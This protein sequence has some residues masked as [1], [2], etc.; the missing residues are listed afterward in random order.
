MLIL[1][2]YLK[3]ITYLHLVKVIKGI[4]FF[5]LFYIFNFMCGN[6]WKPEINKIGF[7]PFFQ[8]HNKTCLLANYF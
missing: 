2:N 3:C 1:Q 7:L 5:R 6:I 4:N 8:L